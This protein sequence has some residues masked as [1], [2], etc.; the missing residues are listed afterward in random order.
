MKKKTVALL[1]AGVLAVGCGIGGTLAWLTTKTDPVVNTFTVGNINITLDESK[2]ENDALN[3]ESR[4]YNNTYKMVPGDT[5]PK[6]PKVTVQAN[7][8]ACYLFVKIQKSENYDTFMENYGTATGWTALT[9]VTLE[10]NTAV[11]YREVSAADAAT[12]KEFY[13]L[14][15]AE[16]NTTGEISIKDTVTKTLANNLT[17]ANYPKLTFTA[18][19]CQKDNVDSVQ[20]A[21]TSV[22]N[23]GAPVQT[24]P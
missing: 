22:N 7:S 5:V 19:A 6:E 18:Y 10:P 20:D 3:T 11:Y 15:G 12:G 23:N 8:E 24:T 16:P 1:M 13:V 21:W 17:E 4:V 14:S 2:Y 9:G